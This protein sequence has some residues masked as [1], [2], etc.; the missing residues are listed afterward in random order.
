[1][2]FNVVSAKKPHCAVL[3][4]FFNSH[5]KNVLKS[6]VDQ[7]IVAFNSP[8]KPWRKYTKAPYRLKCA[9]ALML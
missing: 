6:N 1:M 7:V 5:S 3:K 8:C 4:V 9:V 2:Q